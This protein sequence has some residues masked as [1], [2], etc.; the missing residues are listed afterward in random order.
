MRAVEKDRKE[1]FLTLTGSCR[2]SDGCRLRAG[3]NG[4]WSQDMAERRDSSSGD[5]GN[6]WVMLIWRSLKRPAG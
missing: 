6:T 2:R 5:T 4:T 1:V 3:C